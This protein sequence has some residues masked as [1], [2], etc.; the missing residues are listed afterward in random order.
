MKITT[1]KLAVIGMLGGL[2]VMLEV[3]GVGIIQ[4][5]FLPVQV[6]ILH[7]PT[8]IG[9]I[10]EGPIVGLFIGLIFGGFSMYRAF[11]QP[12]SPLAI[13]FMDPLVSILPRLLIPLI[14]YYAFKGVQNTLRLD[15]Q[16]KL[17]ISSMTA[18]TLGTLTNTIGVLGI[19]FLRYKHIFAELFN[20]DQ[21]IVG[22]T[23]LLGIAIP[24][25]IPETIFAIL[26]ITPVVQALKA[27]YNRK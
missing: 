27:L 10:I 24:N 13:A 7:I 5:P 6:T 21:S 9:A 4:L 17:A 23:I 8:I 26:I 11:A 22:K 16:H 2:S 3:A 1:R 25:G 20:V 19:A 14:S 18:A 12:A 15:N